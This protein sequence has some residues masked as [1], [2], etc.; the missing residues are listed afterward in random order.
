MRVSVGTGSPAAKASDAETTAKG[1]VHRNVKWFMQHPGEVEGTF[2]AWI[3]L[4]NSLP[5]PDLA[6]QDSDRMF[7]FFKL[8]FDRLGR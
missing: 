3:R 2:L 6:G 4:S 7:L 1:I 8:A 5:S